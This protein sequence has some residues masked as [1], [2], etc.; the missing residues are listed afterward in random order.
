MPWSPCYYHLIPV[1][2]LIQKIQDVI[3]FFR[4][5][6]SNVNEYKYGWLL[7]LSGGNCFSTKWNILFLKAIFLTETFYILF[8][9]LKSVQIVSW[10]YLSKLANIVDYVIKMFHVR[11]VIQTHAD[12]V[13]VNKH[14]IVWVNW[15][16]K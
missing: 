9:I 5:S 8:Y 2:Y 3:H 12:V 6:T 4:K 10:Y 14:L 13:L 7:H 16:H 1:R 11:I 15:L